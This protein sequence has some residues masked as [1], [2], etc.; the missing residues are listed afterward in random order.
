MKKQMLGPAI[1]F[2]FVLTVFPA[3]FVVSYQAELT[4]EKARTLQMIAPYRSW[5]KVNPKPIVITLDRS[6][7][8]G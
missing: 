8:S 7:I 4:S 5:G 1:L 6:A 2:V 3:S